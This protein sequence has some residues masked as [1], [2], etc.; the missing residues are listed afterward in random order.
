MPADKANMVSQEREPI[1][2]AVPAPSYANKVWAGAA[3]LLAGLGLIVLGGCFLIGVMLLSA[4]GFGP[5]SAAVPL[6]RS[7]IILIWVLY[8]LAFISFACAAIV[9]LSGLRALF[10]VPR[11]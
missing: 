8:G 10:R 11:V 5:N 9:L 7:A 4:N 1:A 6:T 2:Y 3:I